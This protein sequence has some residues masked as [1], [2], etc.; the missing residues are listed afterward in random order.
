MIRPSFIL[1]AILAVLSIGTAETT[2][3]QGIQ[4]NQAVRILV[5][6]VPDQDRTT[7]NGEY[8]VSGEGL[9]NMPMI[10]RLKA[11]GLSSDAFARA[12]EKAYIDAG[13]YTNPAFQVFANR[14]ENEPVLQ[15]VH[16]GGHVRRPGPVPFANGLTAWQAVQA[17]GGE[18]EFGEMRDVRLFRNGRVIQLNLARNDAK[19]FVLRPSDTIEV[20]QKR[21]LRIPR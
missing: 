7:I 13:I 12:L 5:A 3:D 17:A 11:A 15:V 9:V 6:N 19:Q 4:P 18:T 16:I 20:P 14:I 21:I 1:A 8:P 10:G 2:A